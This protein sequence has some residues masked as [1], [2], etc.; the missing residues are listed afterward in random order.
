MYMTTFTV[1]YKMEDDDDAT[2]AA[3]FCLYDYFFRAERICDQHG[4]LRR[5]EKFFNPELCHENTFHNVFRMW[6][7]TF[8]ELHDLF[9]EEGL[10]KCVLMSPFLFLFNG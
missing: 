1:K 5:A 7:P 6:R 4:A 9:I 8:S 2:I 3:V 10:S